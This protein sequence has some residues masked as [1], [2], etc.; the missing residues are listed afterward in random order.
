MRQTERH[1]FARRLEGLLDY[2]YLKELDRRLAASAPENVKAR[3]IAA[4]F[5]KMKEEISAVV[6]CRLDADTVLDPEKAMKR[7][8]TNDDAIEA[9]S[10]IARWICEL[11]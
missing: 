10:R 4:E 11:E 8:F 3:R 2:A 6:P 7:R 5:G 9:R 1:Q